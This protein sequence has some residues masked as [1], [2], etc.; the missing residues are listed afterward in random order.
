MSDL[1][2]DFCSGRTRGLACGWGLACRWNLACWWSR[3]W[4]AGPGCWGCMFLDPPRLHDFRAHLHAVVV[5][6]M[7]G[8]PG[9]G[10]Y[11]GA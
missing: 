3:F 4:A 9:Q 11:Q 5:W 6:D 8:I 7:V 1:G 10:D 2:S